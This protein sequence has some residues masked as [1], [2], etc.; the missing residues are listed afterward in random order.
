[1]R[2]APLVAIA[3]LLC[4]AAASGSAQTPTP[5]GQP[6]SAARSDSSGTL[7][8]AL[9]GTEDGLPV[10]YGLVR[11]VETG[12]AQ[13]ADSAG[14]F[15][16]AGLVPGTYT[17]RARQIGY[18]PRDTTVRI[19]PAPAETKVI[20]HLRRAPPVLGVVTIRDT[21][22]ECVAP[23][24]P[25]STVNPGLAAIFTQLR[26]NVDRFR[27][28]LDEYPFRFRRE[29]RFVVR[30]VPGGEVT[31]LADTVSYESQSTRPYQVGATVYVEADSAGQAHRLMGLPTFRELA[32]S[33]FLSTHC[34][35][36]AG[37]GPL[38]PS[39]SE[40]IRIEFHPLSTIAAPDV[41][42]SIYLDARRFIVRRAVFRM[43]KPGSAH[44]PVL[45]LAVTT[46]F[47][48]FVPFVPVFDSVES[49]QRLPRILAPGQNLSANSSGI[50]AESLK[51]VN[52]FSVGY[53]RLLD[54]AFEARAPGEQVM[55]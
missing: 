35:D 40:V 23:G 33:S 55:P 31:R 14:H 34:F 26:E 4:G 41:E 19:N 7:T 29:E 50:S 27:V 2:L 10:P 11:L 24:V 20:V 32:D 9:V 54:V 43:T 12:A 53:Y 36:Y 6:G 42:G 28:L 5:S 13:F 48:E 52:R 47:R 39:G 18:S 37:T 51:W 30:F 17:L 3:G 25:D 49:S 16:I 1:M 22:S 38:G 46:T 8:G 15:R 44:P 21:A 45:G